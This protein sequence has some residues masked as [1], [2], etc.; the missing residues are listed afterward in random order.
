[1][2][3]RRAARYTL[4][5]VA[6]VVILLLILV[7]MLTRTEYGV[8]R[9]GQLALEQ[10]RRSIEGEIH[11]DRITSGS[12]L[13]GVTLHGVTLDDPQGRPFL[14]ADSA[15]LAYR[16]RTLLG[17]AIVFDRLILHSPDVVIERLPGQE[18]WNYDR[19]FPAD[20]AATTGGLILISDLVVTGGRATVRL[21]WEPDGP[22]APDDTARLILETV[23]G[24]TVRTVRFTGINARL[25]RIVWEA[26][27][28]EGRLLEVEELSARAHIYETPLEIESLEGVVVIRDSLVSFQAP[29]VRLPASA[30]AAVGTIMLHDE[31]NEYDVQI[32]GQE[33]AFSDFQ[34]LYPALPRDGGGELQLRIQSQGPGSILWLAREARLQTSGNELAG[35]FGVV[36]GDTLYF[37]NVA[38][39][40]APLDLDLV[41]RLVPADLPIEGLL[42][43]TVEVEGPISA[44]ETRGD[45]R[46]RTFR[47]GAGAESEV[48]WNGTVSGA[49]P[50]RVTGLT[51]EMRGLDL[52]QVAQ[53][54]PGLRL[55]GTATGRIRATGSLE[56]GLDLAGTLALD[57]DGHRSA[58]RGSGRFAPGGDRSA[59]DLRLEAEPVALELLV[60]QFPGLGRLAGEARGPVEVTGTL[61]DLRVEADI[62]TPAGGVLLLGRFALQRA[63]PRYRAEGAV[64]EFQLHRL[65]TD[66]PETVVT[67]RFDIE[68]A[69]N[70]LET[71]DARASIDVVS[72][73][74]AG[75]AIRP[76]AVRGTLADGLLRLDSAVVVTEVGAATATG[77]LGLVPGRRGELSVTGR[78]DALG[79]LEPIFFPGSAIDELDPGDLAI[80]GPEPGLLA[81]ATAQRIGGALDADLVVT[82]SI[83]DWAVRG[84]AAGRDLLF[85]DLRLA[86]AEADFDW[87]PDSVTLDASVDAVVYQHRRL[88]SASATVA[89]SPTGGRLIGV[90]A[91]VGPQRLDVEGAF[92]RVGDD[93]ELRLRQLDLVT[94]DG[95]WG[96]MDTV[97]ARVSREGVR[98][99][100]LVLLRSPRYARILVS[101]NM[102]WRHAGDTGPLPASLVV[103]LD[104]VRIGEVLRLAQIDTTVDGVV[105]GEFR[106]TGTAL[107]PR[108]AGRVMA[109]PFRYGGAVL[110]SAGGEIDYADRRIRTRFSGWQGGDP[111]IAGSGTV[112]VD[113]ALTE[114]GDRLLDEPLSVR[115]QADSVPA[116]LVSFLA[117]GFRDVTG[118]VDGSLALVGT[119]RDPGLEG[120]LRLVDGAAYFDPL[121]VRY[122]A[123]NVSARMGTGR[124]VEID[125]RIATGTGT[126]HVLGTLDLTRPRDP[127]LDLEVTAREL[128]ATR[129]RDV[130]L[131]A[132][133]R[134]RVSGSYV[135]PIISGDVRI[136]GGE[137]N[138]DEI[139]RQYQIVQLDPAL[140]HL[141]DS[142]AVSFRP[143]PE[144]PFLEN[145]VL[146][147]ATITADRGFWLRSRELNVE[148]SGSLDLELDRQAADL[149]LTGSLEALGG[150]YTLQL[151]QGVP[152]RTFS[153]RGGTIEFVG[154]PGIDPDLSMAAAYTV[155]RAQGDPIHVLAQV[156]GTLKD[157][158]VGLTSDTDLPLSQSDLASYILFGRS[159]AELTQA[160]SDVLSSGIGLVRPVATGMLSNTIQGALAWTGLVDYVAFTT[161]EYGLS[162]WMTE[163]DEGGLRGVLQ[164]TQLE[165]GIDAGRDVSLVLSGR[166]KT[167]EAAAP[168]ASALWRQVGARVEWRFHP[169]WT[170][171]IYVE[172]RFARTP[173]FGFTEIDDRKVWGLSLVR[174]WAY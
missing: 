135:R 158:R 89:W 120:E 94:A 173:S 32:D 95:R 168:A 146:T 123:M 151:A 70:R 30:L 145:L 90:A 88:A 55:R 81:A 103:N 174:D 156:T 46:L 56:D 66:L 97:R 48:R 107:A 160:E 57:R 78:A 42:I 7:V 10:I 153:I 171:E 68:G 52:E 59:F 1:M 104:S 79:R 112:P 133:G 23:P 25:P 2:A 144:V 75:L 47:E 165:I 58:V 5:G 162:E 130:V 86:A 50:F 111:I 29:R 9:S 163:W 172:D 24:G 84:R 134:A 169:T 12:L 21:P 45:V 113:L 157:P 4:V 3:M 155:R 65:V 136:H 80:G 77:S 101:G 44:L 164:N 167:D 33:L 87:R 129:R 18:K 82:G 143:P 161:P 15:R 11:V 108:L 137:L 141:F 114:R 71:V 140:F 138:L 73:R 62:M 106:V 131:V 53:F 170:T 139:W 49:R 61:D 51:A 72:A 102:P 35:S 37:T 20:T 148:V 119:S 159:G 34:W 166:L 22:V 149:R 154:T 76:S 39:E 99:D 14:R 142:T 150:N 31:E 125:G 117:P 41:Q 74:V 54:A 118:T 16:F 60:E 121:N 92:E 98:V 17:G 127:G 115:F 116:G 109:R 6:V 85:D 132:T 110:D 40:A 93:L 122:Q 152:G 147:N 19:I 69:G 83:H 100:S 8:E 38:L 124:L 128:D 13:S 36:T 26:P 43:G 64:S 27:E 63:D 96:V 91:G 126:G 67:G 105:S 28:E